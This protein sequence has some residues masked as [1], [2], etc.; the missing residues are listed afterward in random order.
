MLERKYG[1]RRCLF[2]CKTTDKASDYAN[3]EK[4]AA[5]N[6]ILRH[7]VEP[8]TDSL[9]IVLSCVFDPSC[10]K[11]SAGPESQDQLE[12]K[13]R[14]YLEKRGAQY[15]ADTVAK[16]AQDVTRITDNG[17]GNYLI[18]QVTNEATANFADKISGPVGWINASA[19]VVDILANSGDK[20]K[21]Y[22]FY[23]NATSM[24]SLYI[25]YRSQADEQNNGKASAA[26]TGSLVS[27]LGDNAG[28]PS[29][30]NQPAEASPLYS[31]LMSNGSGQSGSVL[32]AFAPTALAAGNSPQP[33]GSRYTCD[34]DKTVPGGQLVCP[35]ESLISSN[36]L[37]GL[38][39]AFKKNDL[40]ANVKALADGWN[41]ISGPVLDFI[42]SIITGA[43]SAVLA[44][45]QSELDSLNSQ[46]TKILTP[47]AQDIAKWLIPSPITDQM[48]GARAFNMIAGGTDAAGAQYTQDG[49]G[50]QNIT[51][52]QAADIRNQ[53]ENEARQQFAQQPFFARMFSTSSPYSLVSHVAMSVPTGIGNASQSSFANLISE[54]FS[55]VIS[56]FGS[57]FASPHTQALTASA[58]PFGVP[59][60][61][62]LPT[63]PNLTIS[64]DTL[65]DDYC[66]TFNDAWANDVTTDPTTGTDAHSSTNPCLLND[67]AVGSAGGYFTSSV[68]KP[69]D[70]GQS[71][72]TGPAG[73][74]ASLVWPF[75]TKNPSQYNRVDQGWD[76][77]TDAGGAVYA[78]ASGTIR[79][80]KTDPCGF[81]NDY[82]VEELDA[83]IGGPSQSVYYGHVHVLPELINQHVNAGQQIANTNSAQG[84]CTA[85]N[86]SGA[87]KGW[88]EIGFSKPGTDAPFIFGPE[89]SATSA[90]QAMHDIL[91]T[92]EPAPAAPGIDGTHATT[93]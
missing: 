42:N 79:T 3:K 10:S 32:S 26:L 15:D 76:V 47:L 92:A 30:K 62:Y 20:I 68:L 60:K 4:T 75:A 12:Q 38:S 90:G 25:L 91:I 36:F 22:A 59:Q 34:N 80:F 82:P 24:V 66:K 14:D 19:Q 39:D 54:P 40:L 18:A 81:G 88:L 87:P 53:Q 84:N 83:S 61:G 72:S 56:G 31:N 78:I 49:L 50:G 46:V 52:T 45:I 57:I 63:D 64:P 58:D 35:E 9:G 5:T 11:T 93:H 7:V 21:R 77:Q 16:I 37:T 33:S 8:H 67:A 70:L 41:T 27:T 51:P 29:H 69:E 85:Q 74:N 2:F 13:L 44:P 89:G 71:G 6:A 23:V 86:W 28:D 43:T 48:S 55:K 1:I 73:T 65:T 17:F